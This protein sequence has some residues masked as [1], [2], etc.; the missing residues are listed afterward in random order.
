MFSVQSGCALDPEIDHMHWGVELAHKGGVLADQVLNALSLSKLTRV[1]KL[2]RAARRK[3]TH[4]GSPSR[5]A[6]RR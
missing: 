5:A 3:E 6:L 1:A 2:R 4:G